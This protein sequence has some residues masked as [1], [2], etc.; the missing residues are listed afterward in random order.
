MENDGFKVPIVLEMQYLPAIQYFGLGW[1]NEEILLDIFENYQ[2]QSYRNRCKI[3][4]A[5]GIHE[6]VVPIKHAERKQILKDV[7]IDYSQKWA[8]N[9]WR[10]ICSAYG[11]APFFEYYAD[12]FATLFQQKFPFLWDLNLEI[13]TI[14]LEILGFPQSFQLSK[15]Y[16]EKA[17]FG[18]IRD[19]RSFIHPKKANLRSELAHFKPYQQVFGKGFAPN[20]SIIDLIMCEGPNAVNF[21]GE[22]A[23]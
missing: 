12:S 18:E 9:H 2:K 13:L 11:K 3:M 22:G 10:T 1:Q 6:L 8:T 20:L 17:N 23:K 14:C 15:Q 19:F 5:N 4:T 7:Q 16:I 21:L